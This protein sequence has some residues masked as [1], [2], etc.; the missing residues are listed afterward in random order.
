MARAG[1]QVIPL[2]GFLYTV[3]AALAIAI[4]IW[5]YSAYTHRGNKTA[6]EQKAEAAH[7]TTTRAEVLVAHTDTLWLPAQ[8]EYITVRDRNAANPAAHALGVACDSALAA[9]DRRVAARDTLVGALKR[10]LD[11]WQNKPGPPR[12]QAFAEGLYDLAHSVPVARLGLTARVAGP[13]SLSAAGEYAAPPA[14]RSDPAF[15]ATVGVRYT[16]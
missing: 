3:G 16:F 8:K 5:S 12:V 15:R 6:F 9:Q 4:G 10:E 7:D 13:I 11:V 2:K 1:R 14:G